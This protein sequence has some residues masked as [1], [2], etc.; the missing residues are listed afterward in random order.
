MIGWRG[1]RKDG[2]TGK[3]EWGKVNVD[4][5]KCNRLVTRRLEGISSVEPSFRVDLGEV[6]RRRLGIVSAVVRLVAA[7]LALGCPAPGVSANFRDFASATTLIFNV[8]R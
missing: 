7:A 4:G 3:E 8:D 1:T 6:S 5:A 2:L